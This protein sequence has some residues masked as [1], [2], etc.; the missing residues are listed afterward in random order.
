MLGGIHFKVLELMCKKS[1]VNIRIISL[2]S[3]YSTWNRRAYLH[4]NSQLEE[5]NK[6]TFYTIIILQ[7]MWI[8][9]KYIEEYK[10]WKESHRNETSINHEKN[11]KNFKRVFLETMFFMTTVYIIQATIDGLAWNLKYIYKNQ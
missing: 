11:T 1:Q 6:I 8:L 3:N 4:E 2:V 5:S 7:T 10:T 9:S